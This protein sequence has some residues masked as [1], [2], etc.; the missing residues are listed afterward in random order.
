MTALLPRTNR[1]LPKLSVPVDGQPPFPPRRSR[2]HCGGGSNG[3]YRLTLLRLGAG[4]ETYG[5]C[6]F[7]S[8]HRTVRTIK[9]HSNTPS[10]MDALRRWPGDGCRVGGGRLRLYPNRPPCF[11]PQGEFRGFSPK[12][13]TKRR[14]GASRF[15][16]A[17]ILWT[18]K[19]RTIRSGRGI[20]TTIR[21][22]PGVATIRPWFNSRGNRSGGRAP[23]TLIG[24]SAHNPTSWP[25]VFH[26][27]SQFRRAAHRSRQ[28]RGRDGDCSPPPAQ[29]PACAANA[30]GSYLGSN[31]GRQSAVPTQRPAHIRHSD[32]RSE[33]A[34]I[35][36]AAAWRLF[37]LVEALPS[38]TSAGGCPPL[39][40]R[41]IG[42]MAPSD[43]SS[44][45]MLGAR[46]VAF[47]SR[48]EPGFGYG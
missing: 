25:D 6:G 31:V 16:R 2:E 10:G 47:P 1:L 18:I 12:A 35:R 23:P 34:L 22:E 36:T 15:V 44:T 46:L 29:I 14:L 33:P 26:I 38:T 40:G 7:R 19:V 43:F 3:F 24:P 11:S 21:G 42:T 13:P 5:Q 41:F 28:G 9:E 17:S 45:C 30:P 37:P 48:P 27:P 39:F 20:E 4:G 32:R 8:P